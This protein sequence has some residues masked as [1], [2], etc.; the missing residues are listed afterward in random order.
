MVNDVNKAVCCRNVRLNN[1][2]INTT[3]LDRNRFIVTM[4]LYI[5]VEELLVDMR[6]NLNDLDLKRVKGKREFY[7][8]DPK[9][10][11]ILPF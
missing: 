1:C 9:K 10:N 7:R 4:I 3:A 8:S 2:C 5:K 6:W 11:I